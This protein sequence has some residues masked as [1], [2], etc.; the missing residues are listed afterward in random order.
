VCTNPS[1]ADPNDSSNPDTR[2][3]LTHLPF[4][5][6]DLIDGDELEIKSTRTLSTSRNFLG[7]RGK[8]IS[9]SRSSSTSD[10]GSSQ[11]PDE[12]EGQLALPEP[13]LKSENHGEVRP[14]EGLVEVVSSANDSKEGDATGL[15]ETAY[16]AT[17]TTP[18]EGA[19][20]PS[21]P[22]PSTLPSRVV[23]QSL[24]RGKSSVFGATSCEP[25][26]MPR[27]LMRSLLA[28]LTNAASTDPAA[29]CAC[30]LCNVPVSPRYEPFLVD[31]Q[32]S[33]DQGDF[34]PRRRDPLGAD[35]S[36]IPSHSKSSSFSSISSS[37]S[38]LLEQVLGEIKKRGGLPVL[39]VS[40]RR[41]NLK[42]YERVFTGTQGVDWMLGSG[43][44]RTRADGVALGNVTPFL[45]PS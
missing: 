9:V 37:G 15:R 39:P 27:C 34:S 12:G 19:K 36:S 18:E 41:Y 14:S 30:L 22:F 33:V 25:V 7:R 13:G 2:V 11:A 40:N 3:P 31:A 17:G 1:R 44:V 20:A 38:G 42:M 4:L 32:A 5:S 43:L 16:D 10:S 24:E 8:S 29:R 28:T 21:T 23:S 35:N 26:S 6:A 45:E